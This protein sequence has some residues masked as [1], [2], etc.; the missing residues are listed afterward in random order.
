MHWEE[1][2]CLNLQDHWGMSSIQKNWKR[3]FHVES[4]MI[5]SCLKGRD[6]SYSQ[7]CCPSTHSSVSMWLSHWSCTLSYAQVSKDPFLRALYFLR[8]EQ[9][10]LHRSNQWIRK[11]KWTG[12]PC[13]FTFLGLSGKKPAN[14][15]KRKNSTLAGQ[16]AWSSLWMG[17]ESFS[18]CSGRSYDP[19]EFIKSHMAII[20]IS[21]LRL[22]IFKLKN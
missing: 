4:C 7:F 5:T 20:L 2:W 18:T 21:S 8:Q 14:P 10:D 9:T 12:L 1:S 19:L 13:S 22:M 17:R 6:N 15:P 16:T 3:G 11:G